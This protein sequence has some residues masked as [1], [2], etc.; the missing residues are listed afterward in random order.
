MELFPL[1]L[2][3]LQR[4]TTTEKLSYELNGHKTR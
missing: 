2:Q 1:D 3:F 4:Q